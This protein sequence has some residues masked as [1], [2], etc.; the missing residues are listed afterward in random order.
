MPLHPQFESLLEA[1]RDFQGAASIPVA[2]LRQH[3]R[4]AS[5]A[6]PTLDVPLQSIEER[7]IPGPAKPITVRVYTPVGTAP[8]PIIVYMHGGG[9]VVGDLDTQ[10]MIARGLCHGGEAI[11]VS[12]DYRLAPEHP[13]PAPVDDA[14]AALL[15]AHHEAV[16]IGGDPARLAVAGDSAG[17][18]LAAAIALRARDAGGPQLTGQILWYGSCNY[19]SIDTPSAIEFADG[20]ILTRA[21]T[22]FFWNQYLSAPATDQNHPWA[23]PMRATSHAG[24]PP[25]FVGTAELDPSRDDAEDYGRALASAGVPAEIR[26]YPGMVH[27][28][29]SWLGIVEGANQSMQEATDWLKARF[30]RHP[31]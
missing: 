4:A 1:S 14:W 27:G 23:S 16:S 11:L 13:F 25:A 28:F 6:F 10:D 18:I 22:E 2:E 20:P 31:A 24:L 8:F 15:W 30:T 19:P 9:F 3:V 26:R 21:D 7:T 17:A 5:T 29:I 12:V